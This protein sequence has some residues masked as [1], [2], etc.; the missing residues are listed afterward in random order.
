MSSVFENTSSV[1][2]KNKKGNEGTEPHK[3]VVFD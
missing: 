1:C 2:S 3:A